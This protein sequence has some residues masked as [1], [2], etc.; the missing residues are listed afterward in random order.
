MLKISSIFFR[1]SVY[2]SPNTVIGV[3]EVVLRRAC[4]ISYAACIASSS[5]ENIGN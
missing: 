2:L 1:I 5:Y 4:V 3:V